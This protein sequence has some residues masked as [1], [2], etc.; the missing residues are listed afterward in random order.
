MIFNATGISVISL[1]KKCKRNGSTKC[2]EF[3]IFSKA[4]WFFSWRLLKVLRKHC[5]ERER[6]RER[7]R[8]N[9][10]GKL[11]LP[12]VKKHTRLSYHED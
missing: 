11:K 9:A 5:H 7:E 12:L 3:I 8:E 2:L 10:C 1:V 6:E 4:N